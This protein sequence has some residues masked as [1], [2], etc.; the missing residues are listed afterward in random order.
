MGGGP[1]EIRRA[2]TCVVS[3][4]GGDMIQRNDMTQRNGAWLSGGTVQRSSWVSKLFFP[5][6]LRVSK[7]VSVFPPRSLL[8]C[9]NTR[10]ERVVL[11]PKTDNNKKNEPRMLC[12]PEIHRWH[13]GRLGWRI[14]HTEVAPATQAAQ[15]SDRWCRRWQY[16]CW[17]RRRC[18]SWSKRLTGCGVSLRARGS[19]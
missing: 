1:L 19:Q 8:T 17:R 4:L 9:G 3:R 16:G 2:D 15:V 5:D 10:S 14:C 13:R 11:L 18:C 12:I 7:A 6:E